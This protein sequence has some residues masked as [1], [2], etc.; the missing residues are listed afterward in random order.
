[1]T[2]EERFQRLTNAFADTPGVTMPG[3]GR[4]FGS[5][6][7]RYR[8]RIFALLTDGRLVVKLP[9]ARVDALVAAGHG[10]R[11]DANKGR[12]MREWLR[13]DPGSRLRWK[14]LAAEAL[15]FVGGPP[16]D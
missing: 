6:A 11:F 12:P 5:G 15:A 8:R 10:T 4:G 1:M 2:P 3:A 13:L 9:A 7:L 16:T 14:R